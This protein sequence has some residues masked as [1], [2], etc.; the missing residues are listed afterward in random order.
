MV[1]DTMRLLITGLSGLRK[2]VPLEAVTTHLRDEG[3]DITLLN[4]GDMM[5]QE[6]P[7]I[8]HGRILDLPLTQLRQLR[9]TVFRDILERKN[10]HIILNSHA[11][12][13]W[14]TGLFSAFDFDQIKKFSA[15]YCINVVEDVDQTWLRLKKKK[16]AGLFDYTMKD[17]F[18]WREEEILA[19]QLI[20]QIPEKR[21]EFLLI[22]LPDVEMLLHTLITRPQLR[23]AYISFPITNVLDKPEIMEQIEDFKREMKKIFLAFDPYSVKES[24]M[25]SE[26]EKIRSGELERDFIEVEFEGSSHELPIAEV[27]QCTR[28]INGQII[29][30]DL[31]LID[32]SDMVIAYMPDIDNQPVNSPG[33][34]RE[35][36]HA[37]HTTKDVYIIWTSKREASPFIK[38]VVQSPKGIFPSVT[39]AV[40]EL[41]KVAKTPRNRAM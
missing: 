30:R 32:Q 29:T 28:D 17:L 7:G 38:D 23:R 8:A 6:S 37:A 18:V 36:T 24:W 33:V 10:E 12:F 35:I 15:N 11:T 40:E 13:R 1:K 5:Y 19:T 21:S 2:K 20:S 34:M 9:R 22:P 27:A 16:T 14:R 26:V 39:K 41:K 31:A 25:V 3:Y 4:V